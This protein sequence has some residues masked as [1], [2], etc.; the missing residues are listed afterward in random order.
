MRGPVYVWMF[1]CL[2]VFPGVSVC[3][4]ICLSVYLKTTL[5]HSSRVNLTGSSCRFISHPYLTRFTF[6]LNVTLLNNFLWPF[7]HE[8]VFLVCYHLSEKSIYILFIRISFMISIHLSTTPIL[9]IFLN[10]PPTMS[11]VQNSL[12]QQWIIISR[13]HNVGLWGCTVQLALRSGNKTLHSTLIWQ[14]TLRSKYIIC[15]VP[16]K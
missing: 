3:V 16:R 1:E 4:S 5:I 2:T 8:L 11:I 10:S 14:N 15:H 7:C 9:I 6:F 12:R 13:E